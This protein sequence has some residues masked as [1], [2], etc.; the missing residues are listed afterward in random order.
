MTLRTSSGEGKADGKGDRESGVRHW[1]DSVVGEGE[2]GSKLRLESVLLW[3]LVRFH[4]EKIQ[5]LSANKM[6]FKNKSGCVCG[7]SFKCGP[8]CRYRPQ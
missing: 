7:G 5:R 6:E 1:G 8:W 4:E 2:R 3:P